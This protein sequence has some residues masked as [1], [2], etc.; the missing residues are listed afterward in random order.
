MS[1]LDA[2]FVSEIVQKY[3]LLNAN[4]NQSFTYLFFQKYL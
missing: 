4:S 3:I 2:G 1:Q